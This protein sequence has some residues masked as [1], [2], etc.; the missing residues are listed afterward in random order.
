MAQ[1]P[2]TEASVWQDHPACV[3]IRVEDS[4]AGLGSSRRQALKTSTL[5]RKSVMAGLKLEWSPWLPPF[6]TVNKTLK[7][8][9]GPQCVTLL[10]AENVQ[11]FFSYCPS[12]QSLHPPLPYT[13]GS[14]IIFQLLWKSRCRE[15]GTSGVGGIQSGWK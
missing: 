11:P 5:L 9:R 6:G 1:A 7:G 12:P 2:N 10:R 3:G 4:I 14:S 8:T 13:L 15:V